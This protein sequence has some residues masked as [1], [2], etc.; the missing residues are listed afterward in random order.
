MGHQHDDNTTR[1]RAFSR[2]INNAVVYKDDGQLLQVA[3]VMMCAFE[4][5]TS[6]YN[7]NIDVKERRLSQNLDYILHKGISICAHLCSHTTCM[8]IQIHNKG[9]YVL[10]I[11]S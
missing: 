6:N 11:Y 8:V 3:G 7:A 10:I 1:A 5:L 9:C 2:S 4:S